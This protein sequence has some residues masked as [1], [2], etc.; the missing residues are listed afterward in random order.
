M[1]KIIL[2]I[3]VAFMAFLVG[4]LVAFIAVCEINTSLAK[5]AMLFLVAFF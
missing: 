1:S 4:Y 5:S 3:P 2:F